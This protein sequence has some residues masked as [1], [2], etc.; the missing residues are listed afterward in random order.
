M[1]K[2]NL[3][4]SLLDKASNLEKVGKQADKLATKF[5]E[6][7][8]DNEIIGVAVIAFHKIG[9]VCGLSYDAEELEVEEMV[10]GLK[11][12]ANDLE[13][14]LADEED[15][16]PFSPS[17]KMLLT[18]IS[19]G[20]LESDGTPTRKFIK[21]A[22]KEIG[23]SP[24]RFEKMTDLERHELINKVCGSP[25]SEKEVKEL[26]KRHKEYDDED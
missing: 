12:Q 10:K 6:D 24:K 13:I 9:S 23:E 5:R 21:K 8:E 15:D 25:L 14:K 19:Q 18:M 1:K 2:E 26:A 20:L 16:E 17:A 7:N 22:F 11:Q 4:K 3:L